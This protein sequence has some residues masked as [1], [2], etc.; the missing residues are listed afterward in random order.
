MS[1]EELHK[2]FACPP[3]QNI[4]LYDYDVKIEVIDNEYRDDYKDEEERK[5][6]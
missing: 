1:S 2:K 5:K 6:K 3:K 4:K